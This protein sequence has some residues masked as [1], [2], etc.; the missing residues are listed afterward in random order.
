MKMKKID[1]PTWKHADLLRLWCVAACTASMPGT[2][3]SLLVL[4]LENNESE[5]KH[6]MCERFQVTN[7]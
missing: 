4:E 3:G 7:E 5:L 1:L 2:I 6:G